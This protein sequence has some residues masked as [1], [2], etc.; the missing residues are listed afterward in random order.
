MPSVSG[1]GVFAAYIPDIEE[2]DERTEF[3]EKILQANNYNYGISEEDN[4]KTEIP[5]WSDSSS[6]ASGSKSKFTSYAMQFAGKSAAEMKSIMTSKG[7][8]FHDG[9]W[10]ADFVTFVAKEAFGSSLPSGFGSPSCAT[11]RSWAEGNGKYLTGSNKGS[12]KPGDVVLFG[13]G[14]GSHTG[15]VT[16]V[17]GDTIETI[18]GNSSNAVNKRSYNI[19]DGYVNG[20]IRL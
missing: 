2:T 20:F 16:A 7:Y 3:R 15:I 18:E 10:C 9:V 12:V 4:V 8:E 11:L 19:N 17:N 6:G 13:A 5:G 14:G 1:V